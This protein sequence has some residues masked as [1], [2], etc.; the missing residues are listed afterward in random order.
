M[1]GPQPSTPSCQVI[2]VG[3]VV[4]FAWIFVT[5]FDDIEGYVHGM[6]VNKG[7]DAFSTQPD[8]NCL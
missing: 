6:P 5:I 1:L 4:F 7:L 3:T 2:Y 8:L